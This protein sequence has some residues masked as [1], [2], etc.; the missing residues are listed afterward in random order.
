MNHILED[1]VHSN[2]VPE[3]NVYS[4][5]Y[6]NQYTAPA[7]FIVQNGFWTQPLAPPFWQ[8]HPFIWKIRRPTLSPSVH[9]TNY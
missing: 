8:E 9:S 3:L 1:I 5:N 4:N 7:R 2:I 6:D